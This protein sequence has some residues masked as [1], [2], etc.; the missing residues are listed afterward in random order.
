MLRANLLLIALA[1][2][3]ALGAVGAQHKSRKLFHE[4]EREQERSRQLEVE[5]GQL[6]LEQSTWAG[7]ARVEKIA[8]ERLHMMTPRAGQLLDVGPP[9]KD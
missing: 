3:C 4:L 6:Q 8:R 9:R 2:A 1:L 5:W 7:H